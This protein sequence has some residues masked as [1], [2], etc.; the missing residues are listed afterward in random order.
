MRRVKRERSSGVIRVELIFV[1]HDEMPRQEQRAI[2]DAI[3][4]EGGFGV[5]D[6]PAT[7]IDCRGG[8]VIE[9]DCVFE[10]RISVSKGFVDGY[11]GQRQIVRIAW[12]RNREFHD[13]GG[14]IEQTSLRNTG[15]L[16]PEIDDVDESEVARENAQR[17]AQI[18]EA[19]IDMVAAVRNVSVRDDLYPTARSNE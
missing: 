1:K 16:N 15:K 13:V 3:F 12:C 19:E 9:F 6:E 5:A 2:R 7:E 10:R 17:F 14:A 18:V 4:L 11:D 8:W